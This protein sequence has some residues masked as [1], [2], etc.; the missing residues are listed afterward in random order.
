MNKTERISD[1]KTNKTHKVA[2]MFNEDLW[3]MFKV[4]CAKNSTKP[5]W[6]LEKWILSYLDKNNMLD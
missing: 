5:T 3:Q 4:T 6:E 1:L 2:F